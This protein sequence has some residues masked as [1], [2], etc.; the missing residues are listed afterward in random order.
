MLATS[1]RKALK[2]ENVPSSLAKAAAHYLAV[3]NA[4]AVVEERAEAELLSREVELQNLVARIR[5]GDGSG[6][7]DLYKIFAKGIRFYLCRHLGVQDLDDRVHDNL[8]MVVK[9]IRRGDLRDPACLIG[10]VGRWPGVRFPPRSI[11]WCTG[12]ATRWIGM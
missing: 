5:N 6:M 8:L 3:P 1:V 12:V 10:F 9:A 11:S 4:T 2:E 7:E